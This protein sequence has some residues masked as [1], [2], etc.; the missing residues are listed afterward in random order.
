MCGCH[1]VEDDVEAGREDA[2]EEEEGGIVR[3]ISKPALA[4]CRGC[5]VGF[6]SCGMLVSAL[7][8]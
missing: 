7:R 6:C 4:L 8:N 2:V 5:W 3:T 1:E